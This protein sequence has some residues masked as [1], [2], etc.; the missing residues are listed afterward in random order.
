MATSELKINRKRKFYGEN[1]VLHKEIV[2]KNVPLYIGENQWNERVC[3]YCNRKNGETKFRNRNAHTLPESIGN[4][5][6]FSNDECIDCNTY[7]GST[8]ESDFGN[9]TLFDRLFF[10]IQ[11]KSNQPPKYKNRDVKCQNTISQNGCSIQLFDDSNLKFKLTPDNGLTL[12][13][14]SFSFNIHSRQGTIS[15]PKEGKSFIP[16]NIFKCFVKMFLGIIDY[17]ELKYFTDTISWVRYNN[18]SG[19]ALFNNRLNL[20]YSVNLDMRTDTIRAC[21]FKRMT[22]N[23][24]LP[25]MSFLLL[26]GHFSY[27][28]VIPFS[29]KDSTLMNSKFIFHG[30][31]NLSY[32]KNPS[33]RI[34]YEILNLSSPEKTCSVESDKVGILSY[35]LSN[36]RFNS[37]PSFTW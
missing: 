1:Y 24:E 30:Y 36:A 5:T 4:K 2:L 23:I 8:L 13:T 7:F 29:S 12:F 15:L 14:D 6:L 33:S 9:F 27:Q 31:P 37:L 20:L 16:K 35:R 21:V 11:G 25:Y 19:I 32:M 10:G 18:E 34:S 17:N 3:R 28:I 26:F 22:D